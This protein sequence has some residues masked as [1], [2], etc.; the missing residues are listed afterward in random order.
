[1]SKHFLH[2]PPLGIGK[3]DGLTYDPLRPAR[4]C[5]ICGDSF[6]P[7]LAK[8]PSYDSDEGVRLAVD[9]L[10]REWATNHNKKHSPQQHIEHVRTGRLMTP[11]AA[12]RLIPLG[13]YPIDDLYFDPE[14]S[15]A[16]FEAPRAPVDDVPNK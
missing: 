2:V 11:E 13:V 1:M 8:S 14:I 10:I 5:G 7:E 15:Q 4:H 6:Q 16:G 3:D 12:V 9:I